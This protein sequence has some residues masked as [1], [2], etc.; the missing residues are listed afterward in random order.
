MSI[1]TNKIDFSQ[2]VENSLTGIVILDG[3]ELLYA[4]QQVY[5]M[6]GYSPEDVLIWDQII[7]PNYRK[8]VDDRIRYVKSEQRT[9]DPIEHKLI[10]NDGSIV[11]VE[12]FSLPY[13]KDDHVYVQAHIHDITKRKV[14]EK[15]YELRKQQYQLISQNTSDIIAELNQDGEIIYVSPSVEEVL[16]IKPSFLVGMSC[17]DC[18]HPEDLSLVKQNGKN[19]IKT[20]QPYIIRYRLRGNNNNY[21]WVE[22]KVKLIESNGISKVVVD[23]RD[24]TEQIEAEKLLRQS[25]KLAVLG[26]LS[27]GV[28]H[29]I[30]NPLTSI[31]GFLQLMQAGTIETKDYISILNTEIEHIEQIASD[32]LG[33]AKPSDEMKK[34][35]LSVLLDSVV[36]LMNAQS[37]KHNVELNWAAPQ[38]EYPVLGDESQIKQVFVNLIKNAIEASEEHGTV[39][40]HLSNRDDQVVIQV[41]DYGCGIP[42]EMLNHIGDS[43]FTTKE[44]GTGLGLMIT[45]KI[46]HNHHGKINIHSIVNEGTTFSVILPK[47]Y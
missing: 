32:L 2:L 44:K 29:E 38:D 40:I 43:F 36:F 21:I 5:N 3:R 24:C 33:F 8:L 19:L 10:K 13:I 9:T 28:V 16:G 46:I 37:K 26:E 18:V 34:Q 14:F 39:E 7:H 15:E 12:T 4:N 11:H 41:Q 47:Y 45:Q 23:A 22:A 6:L 27:A 42:E 17:Y 1:T 25:E 20:K 31:K 35:D 30:K